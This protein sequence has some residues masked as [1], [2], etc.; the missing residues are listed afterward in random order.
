MT[1]CSSWATPIDLVDY[2]DRLW[3]AKTARGEQT[4]ERWVKWLERWKR[5]RGD[6]PSDID[7]VNDAEWAA[8]AELV[9]PA[10]IEVQQRAEYA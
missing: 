9:Q 6:Q 4:P 7:Y 5:I 2:L 10:L 3:A 1:S 8:V